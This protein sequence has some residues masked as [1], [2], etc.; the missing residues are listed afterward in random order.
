MMPACKRSKPSGSRCRSDHCSSQRNCEQHKHLE[1]HIWINDIP[2]S[3]QVP[4][5][6][7]LKANLI[8]F[9]SG[10]APGISEA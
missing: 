10:A 2:L 7:P 4:A 1:Q 3:H 6:D 8:T 9:E 5:A